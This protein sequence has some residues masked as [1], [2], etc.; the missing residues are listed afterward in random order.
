[1]DSIGL[2]IFTAAVLALQGWAVAEGFRLSKHCRCE[3]IGNGV[4][5]ASMGLGAYLIVG[6]AGLVQDFLPML[7][8]GKASVTLRGVLWRAAHALTAIGL[9][10][11]F[12]GTRRLA[13]A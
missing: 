12:R 13:H 9:V 3:N 2:F 7:L 11:A 8:E 5:I 10:M 1:M 4:F 6:L